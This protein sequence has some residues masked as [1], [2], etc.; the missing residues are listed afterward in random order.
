[1]T[2]CFVDLEQNSTRWCS[3]CCADTLADDAIANIRE[4][5]SAYV[6]A[7]SSDGDIM[8]IEEVKSTFLTGDLN[9]AGTKFDTGDV[10]MML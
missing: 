4:Y 7:Y 8:A 9:A 1:M 5:I 6:T 10:G 3:V 2:L